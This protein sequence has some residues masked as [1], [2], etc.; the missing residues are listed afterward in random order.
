LRIES[1]VVLCHFP[2][3]LTE[4]LNEFIEEDETLHGMIMVQFQMKILEQLLLFSSDHEALSLFIHTENT[5]E[6]HALGIY[7]KSAIYE[8]KIPTTTGTKT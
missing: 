7:R 3:I 5:S 8:D 4:Q 1:R 2:N 6:G